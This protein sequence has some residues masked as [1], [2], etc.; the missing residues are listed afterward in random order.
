MLR[1]LALLALGLI[2]VLAIGCNDESSITPL[3]TDD[4]ATT[5]AVDI[6]RAAAE[7]AAVTGWEIVEPG[8]V[9][10]NL[11]VDKSL[12]GWLLNWER[13]PLVDDIVHYSF[14]VR[15][16]PGEFDV[17][18]LHRVV[19]ERRP[20][21]PIRT[22]RA[23]FLQHGCC[24][25]FAGVYLPTLYSDATPWEQNFSV[26]LAQADI[27]VWGI[28]QSWTL[29]EFGTI[30]DDLMRDWG[31]ERQMPDLRTGVA[32]AR[33]VRILTGGGWARF[34]LSGYSNGVP[35]T[36][37]LADYESQ[38]PRWTRNVGALVPVDNVVQVTEG[39]LHETLLAFRGFYQ[40]MFDSGVYNDFECGFPFVAELFE[41]APDDPSPCGEGLT[42]EQYAYV[43]HTSPVLPPAFHYW[44][45]TYGADGLP[46]GFLYTDQAVWFDFI[47]SG[48]AYEPT[49]WS[50]DWIGYSSGTLDTPW[51]DHLGDIRVPVLA[52]AP[53]G[54]FGAAAVQSS[55]SL[56]GSNDVTV[57]EPALGVDLLVEFGHVDLFTAPEAISLWWDPLLAWI[58]DHTH[59]RVITRAELEAASAY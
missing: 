24:K 32:V 26:H 35:T 19:R 5:S 38:Q 20:S 16:G 2:V 10:T 45:P 47:A 36:L 46:D 25:D 50:V 58:D 43:A 37:A 48:T 33:L 8:A 23:I 59:H 12:L 57:L 4:V 56:L 34:I 27:D 42:N 22:G 11:D 28:D 3:T 44:S 53:A 54:G 52:V 7:I 9:D 41:Q 17:I 14:Q 15:V 40:G 13:Q 51:D 29:P 18:G 39:E 6:E 21:R 30:P 31:L 1:F 49:I 55:L